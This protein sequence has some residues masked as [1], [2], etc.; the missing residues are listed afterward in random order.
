MAPYSGEIRTSHPRKLRDPIYNSQFATFLVW[1]DL[2]GEQTLIW[3]LDQLY[4]QHEGR[5]R[6][7]LGMDEKVQELNENADLEW[8]FEQDPAEDFGTGDPRRWINDYKKNA[9]NVSPQKLHYSLVR[10]VM[11]IEAAILIYLKCLEQECH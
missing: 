4:E 11:W 2:S 6:N 7:G 1:L 10:R 5:F 8:I 9:D 3:I